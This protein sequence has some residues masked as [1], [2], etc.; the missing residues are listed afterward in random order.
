M[1][2]KTI[3]LENFA[4]RIGKNAVNINTMQVVKINSVHDGYFMFPDKNQNTKTGNFADYR[5]IVN[6]SVDADVLKIP[7]WMCVMP[8]NDN[9]FCN[10]PIITAAT[11]ISQVKRI[12]LEINFLDEDEFWENIKVRKRIYSEP[13][14]VIA[15]AIFAIMRSNWDY[16]EYTL[17]FITKMLQKKSHATILHAIET[18]S[19]LMKT[20]QK[21]R[22][23]YKKLIDYIFSINPKI[24]L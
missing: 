6:S 13:R 18:V 20:E 12:V 23:K 11:I 2:N 8:I 5:L 24:E 19:N 16:K 10:L 17:T 21:F 9:D 3:Y 14:Q 7:Y 15:A 1:K 22:D 4:K